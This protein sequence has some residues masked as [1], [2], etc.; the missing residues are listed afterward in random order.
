MWIPS[1]QAYDAIDPYVACSVTILRDGQKI[2]DSVSA[3]E[4]FDFFVNEYGTYVIVYRAQDSSGNEVT[5]RFRLA[6]RDDEAP[7]L[8]VLSSV[9]KKVTL[10]KTISIP[11][12]VA[13][14]RQGEAKVRVYIV[15]PTG[16][17]ICLDGQTEY[18]PSVKGVYTLRYYA[19]DEA[20]NSTMQDYVVTV[21]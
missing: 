1:A 21:I 13:L 2:V 7:S 12:A 16:K 11:S 19:Y 20:Y 14:D 17:M 8:T 4:G 9:D 18:K 5:R 6:V 3:A 15:T 10:G